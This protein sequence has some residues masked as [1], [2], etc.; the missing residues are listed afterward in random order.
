MV[1]SRTVSALPCECLAYPPR[2]D[3]AT[4]G[5]ESWATRQLL[6]AHRSTTR[7]PSAVLSACRRSRCFKRSKPHGCQRVPLQ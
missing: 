1:A 2:P 5:V 7:A 4:R 3:F 6:C